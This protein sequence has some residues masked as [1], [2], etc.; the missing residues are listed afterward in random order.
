MDKK[1]SEETFTIM[2]PSFLK[3][4]YEQLHQSFR[5]TR[6]FL[7]KDLLNLN[8]EIG[9]ENTNINKLATLKRKLKESQNNEEKYLKRCITRFNH[10]DSV[11]EL[12]DES[13]KSWMDLRCD[14][15]ICDYLM[16]M[17]FYETAK[18]LVEYK[19]EVSL[20]DFVDMDFFE[21]IHK[22][23]ESLMSGSFSE[24]IAWCNENKNA[25]KKVKL[26]NNQNLEFGVRLQEY[27]ELIKSN[28]HL[29]AISYAKKYLTSFYVTNEKEIHQAMGLLAFNPKTDLEPYKTL[30]SNSRYQTLK[31]LF[32]ST[33][34]AIYSLP[35]T[36]S[37]S[38]ALQS[39][40]CSLKTRSC[41]VHSLKSFNCPCCQTPY[42]ELS[43]NLPF[44][45]YTTS[46]LV[47][48]VTGSLIDEN[49]HLLIFPSGTLIS[50]LGVEKTA[51]DGKIIDYRTGQI[52]DVE[53]LKK[54]FLA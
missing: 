37:L 53:K 22:I 26:P 20:K 31:Y 2:E 16:R 46:S 6:K 19:K 54:G 12:N 40:L 42:T 14:R 32:Q 45:H 13:L 48:K 4:P 5:V 9:D 17:G 44:S 51:K 1:P 35:S 15:Y 34:Y 18:N 47:C 8:L 41:G 24:C 11:G 27:I 7:E 33:I 49:N 30:F 10:L 52:T 43:S 50:A 36:S 23:Q 39:G 21:E 38:L 25:L 28:R 29:D 3:V